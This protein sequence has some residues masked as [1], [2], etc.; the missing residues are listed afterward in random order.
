MTYSAEETG[1][2]ADRASRAGTTPGSVPGRGSGLATSPS[3]RRRRGVFEVL[4]DGGPVFGPRCRS[5]EEHPR[6]VDV[7]KCERPTG[8]EVREAQAHEAADKRW[9]RHRSD[10][11]GG[12]GAKDGNPT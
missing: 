3:E 4:L 12:H 11:G 8:A 10:R 1:S 2:S 9:I 7:Q 5:D 6:A